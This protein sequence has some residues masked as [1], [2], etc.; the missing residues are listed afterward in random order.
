MEWRRKDAETKQQSMEWRR[1]EKT[2]PKKFLRQ[3]ATKKAMCIVF[4]NSEGLIS[5]HMVPSRNVN[6][7]YYASLLKNQVSK[8]LRGMRPG[9]RPESILFLQDNTSHTAMETKDTIWSLG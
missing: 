1:K 3:K 7:H 8:T 6:A 9:R 5:K 2:S 4:W